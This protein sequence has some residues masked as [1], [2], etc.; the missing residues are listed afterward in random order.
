MWKPPNRFLAA[1]RRHAEKLKASNKPEARAPNEEMGK[2][3]TAETQRSVQGDEKA[4]N[5]SERVV[6][7]GREHARKSSQKNRSNSSGRAR[8]KTKGGGGGE[9][10]GGKGQKETGQKGGKRLSKPGNIFQELRE[11]SIFHDV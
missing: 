11:C 1:S 6:A 3:D 5:G 8:R 9:S 10:P 2:E 7:A 4:G